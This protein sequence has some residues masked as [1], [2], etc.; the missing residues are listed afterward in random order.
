MLHE[1]L[2][3]A[4]SYIFLVTEMFFGKK[5]HHEAAYEIKKFTQH[6]SVMFVNRKFN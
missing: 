2:I 6:N 3:Q 4:I 1:H 5:T